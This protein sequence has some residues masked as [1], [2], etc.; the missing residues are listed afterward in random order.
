M[1]K[2][3]QVLKKILPPPVKAFLGRTRRRSW[4]RLAKIEN[5]KKKMLHSLPADSQ[6]AILLEKVSS[7]IYY[8]DG[9]YAGDTEHY[10]SVGLSAVNQVEEILQSGEPC[11]VGEFLDMPCGYGRELRFFVHLLPQTNFTACDFLKSGVDFCAA[12][13]KAK[14][15]YSQLNLDKVVFEKKFDFIWC[16]SLI[17]HLPEVDIEALLVLFSRNLNPNGIMAF[18]TQGEFAAARMLKDIN[19]YGIYQ[20]DDDVLLADYH[21]T[22]FGFRNYP[23]ENG[24]SEINST[25]STYGISLTSPEWIQQIAEK[26][27]GLNKIYF[28]AHGWDNHQDVYGYQKSE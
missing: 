10:F 9:M 22:G 19:F 15:V 16:G 7:R 6:K 13:F 14:P 8:D 2:L 20:T 3:L 1:N 26:I 27:G 25:K 5:E 11:T 24:I 17:T 12:E 18:T 4:S 28:R 21:K 23:Q